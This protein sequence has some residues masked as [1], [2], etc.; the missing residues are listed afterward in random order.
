MAGTKHYLLFLSVLD[1]EEYRIKYEATKA[2]NDLLIEKVIEYT[3]FLNLL[4]FFI[5]RIWS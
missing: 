1:K 3:W 5:K 2:E 4:K